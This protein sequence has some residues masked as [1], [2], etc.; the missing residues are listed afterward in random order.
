MTEPA[1]G[2]LK[3]LEEDH[4]YPF[5]LKHNGYS[6]TQQMVKTKFGI[7]SLVPVINPG[8]ATYKY[9]YNGKELQD[10]LGLNMYVWR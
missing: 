10:D 6:A 7:I 1:D 8:D 9:M 4:Y 5:G 2:V 3:I